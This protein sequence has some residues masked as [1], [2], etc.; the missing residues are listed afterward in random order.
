VAVRKKNKKKQKKSV[1][2][3]CIRLIGGCVNNTKDNL[4]GT[5]IMAAAPLSE[6]TQFT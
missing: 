1:K 4:Y 6:F 3:I 5:V 2:H